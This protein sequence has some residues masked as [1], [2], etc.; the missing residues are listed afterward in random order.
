MPLAE[1]FGKVADGLVGAVEFIAALEFAV[2]ESHLEYPW[3]ESLVV[4]RWS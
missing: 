1:R 3:V 4:G 2:F